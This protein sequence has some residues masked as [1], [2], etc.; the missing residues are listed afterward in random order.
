MTLHQLRIFQVVS[1]HLNIT[2]ASKELRIS[3]PSVFKQVKSLEESYR[4]KLYRKIGRGIELTEQGRLFQGEVEEILRR[5][6]SLEKNLVCGLCLL[7][8]VGSS[9]A[10]LTGHQPL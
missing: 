2:K 9:L 3:Q 10:P 5:V 8:Q 1:H 4:T 7:Q 6:E